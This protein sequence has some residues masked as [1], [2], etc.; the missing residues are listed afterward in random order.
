MNLNDSTYIL[1][2][3]MIL[4]SEVFFC[5]IVKNTKIT[6]IPKQFNII[7]LEIWYNVLNSLYVLSHHTVPDNATLHRMLYREREL[8]SSNTAQ[9]ALTLPLSD[10]RSV[11]HQLRLR[12]V[13]EFGLPDS[14]VEVL[15]NTN[16]YYPPDP[17]PPALPTKTHSLKKYLISPRKRKQSPPLSKRNPVGSPTKPVQ[18]VPPTRS[19]QGA[20]REVCQVSLFMCLWLFIFISALILSDVVFLETKIQ[21]WGHLYININ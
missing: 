8:Q 14:T 4:N 19:S 20:S 3:K 2:S 16:S 1:L 11:H 6:N 13:R 15:Q 5:S 7:I 21:P 18:C 12:T 10:R 9:K 17:P